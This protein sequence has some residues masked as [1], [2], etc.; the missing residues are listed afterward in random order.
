MEAATATTPSAG[1]LQAAIELC[2]TH[3]ALFILDEMITGLRWEIGGA[4]AAFG[5]EPDLSTFGKGLANG[6]ALSAADL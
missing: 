5:I 2:H 4:Q 1:Y 3:G 6:F